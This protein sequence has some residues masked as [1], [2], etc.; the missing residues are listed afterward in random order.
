MIIKG[1]TGNLTF[2]NNI[3]YS[4][5]ADLFLKN[6]Y[7][8]A[9]AMV[10]FISTDINKKTPHFIKAVIIDVISDYQLYF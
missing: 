10:S 2:V 6:K 8:A 4:Q 5:F 1:F 7:L 3:F 9:S